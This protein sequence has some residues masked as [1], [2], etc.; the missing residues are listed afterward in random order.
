MVRETVESL[1]ANEREAAAYRV[2]RDAAR[3]PRRW[4]P[5]FEVLEQRLFEPSLKLRAVRAEHG[6]LKS[7]HTRAFEKVYGCDPGEYLTRLRVETAAALLCIEGLGARDCGTIVGFTSPSG[8]EAAYQRYQRETP[9]ATRARLAAAGLMVSPAVTLEKDALQQLFNGQAPREK[10]IAGFRELRLRRQAAQPIGEDIDE[11]R[12]ARLARAWCRL[13]R[14]EPRPT[15]RRL[16]AGWFETPALFDV[17]MRVVREEGRGDRRRGV[18]IAQLALDSLIALRGSIEA[19]RFCQLEA[20]ALAE[21]GNAHRLLH[22]FSAAERTLNAAIGRLIGCQPSPQLRAEVLYLQ[23]CLQ[24]DEGRF[25]AALELANGALTL[26][27]SASRL[28]A[29]ILLCRG[30]ILADQNRLCEAMVDFSAAFEL[31]LPLNE[32]YLTWGTA[33]NLGK[34]H[35]HAGDHAAA[36]DCLERAEPA[37]R[38]LGERGLLALFHWQIGLICW[39]QEK[40]AQAETHLRRAH[41]TYEQLADLPHGAVAGLDLAWLYQHQG[42]PAEACHLA[43]EVLPQ[44]RSLGLDAEGLAALNLLQQAIEA[45]SLRAEV[46]EKVRASAAKVLSVPER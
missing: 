5:I 15:Q 13:V 1:I 46:F 14:R 3:A 17:L 25:E 8:F 34:A 33:Y 10:A 11:S 24:R 40:L 44:L 43:A 32:P 38:Q 20:R 22:D 16:A 18:E 42:R 4:R 9:T 12:E 6:L 27:K 19:D 45:E 29:E 30:N 28:K 35:H 26:A 31:L 21:L 23:S 39:A 7:R 41:A 2:R 36:Q 37:I